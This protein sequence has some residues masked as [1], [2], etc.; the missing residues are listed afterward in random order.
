MDTVFSDPPG[1]LLVEA[2]SFF[3]ADRPISAVFTAAL[4][5]DD[6]EEVK[7]IL[8]SCATRGLLRRDPADT[9][10]YWKS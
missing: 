7:A 3:P 5:G 10:S 4:T 9:D 6:R 2:I 8:D 1:D